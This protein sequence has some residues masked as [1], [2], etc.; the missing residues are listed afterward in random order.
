MSGTESADKP[1][2]TGK[3]AEVINLGSLTGKLFPW[4][5]RRQ[6]PVLLNMPGSPY[7]YIPL[8]SSK[9]QLEEMMQGGEIPYDD[10]KVIDHGEE[11][12]AGLLESGGDVMQK[13][14]VILDLRFTPEGKVRFT[15]LFLGDES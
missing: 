7:D 15:E 2:P 8:F 14:K 11:F 12:V 3:P 6:Q 5:Q 9:Q 13:T 4:D 10:I 1:K